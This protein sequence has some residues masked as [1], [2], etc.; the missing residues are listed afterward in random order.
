MDTAFLRLYL[1]THD[2]RIAGRIKEA[3]LN[4]LGFYEW[5]WLP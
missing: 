2:T 1:D 3:N 4:L 5:K